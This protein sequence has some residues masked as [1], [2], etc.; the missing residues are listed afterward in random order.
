MEISQKRLK[1]LERAESKLN[2]LEAGGVDNW[3]NYGDSL[4]DWSR[5]IEK[6]D[7]LEELLADIEVTLA[8][9]VEE[10][11]GQRA[12]YGFKESVQME[13]LDILKDYFK[14][15]ELKQ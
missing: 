9:G 13:A 12:G 2:A 3:E 8:Q 10:P 11:A 14:E 7:K 5:K 4:D 6:E 1:E 15:F